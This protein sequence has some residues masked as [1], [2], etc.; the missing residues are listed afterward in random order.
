MIRKRNYQAEKLLFKIIRKHTGIPKN[1]LTGE[2]REDYIVKA[3]CIYLEVLKSHFE[4][5]YTYSV[6]LSIL[7]RSKG[8][9][10]NMRGRHKELLGTDYHYRF[11]LKSVKSEFEEKVVVNSHLIEPPE[12]EENLISIIKDNFH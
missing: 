10:R 7:K 12:K 9:G 3:R 11:I 5:G 8:A 6:I 4:L 1:Q 2:G